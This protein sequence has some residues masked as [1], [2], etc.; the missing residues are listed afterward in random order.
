MTDAMPPETIVSAVERFLSSFPEWREISEDESS[1]GDGLCLHASDDLVNH[2]GAG[3]VAWIIS[4]AT[5]STTRTVL[6]DERYPMDVYTGHAVALID[7]WA[8]DLTARQFAPE[9]P[10]PFYWRPRWVS[11]VRQ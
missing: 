7:G 1:Y 2:V 6:P 10:F 5:T 3:E 8:V 9:L 4:A 11:E